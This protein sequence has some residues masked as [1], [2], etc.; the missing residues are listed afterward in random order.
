MDKTQ[1]RNLNQGAELTSSSDEDYGSEKPPS[2]K[3]SSSMQRSIDR[4]LK[5]TVEDSKNPDLID[6]TGKIK[7]DRRIY[8]LDVY[9]TILQKIK[10]YDYRNNKIHDVMKIAKKEE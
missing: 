9:K 8:D 6:K 7:F 4:L 2:N 3:V 10:G 1:L 5:S